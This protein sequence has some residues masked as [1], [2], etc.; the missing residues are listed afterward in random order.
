MLSVP[1]P[2]AEP[3]NGE[4]SLKRG[5]RHKR[6]FAISGDFE[7]LKKDTIKDTPFPPDTDANYATHC[8]NAPSSSSNKPELNA[9]LAFDTVDS[10]STQLFASP[11]FFISEEP[12]FTGGFK[13]VPD[14][15]INLDDALKTRPRSFKSHRRTESA[16]ADLHLSFNLERKLKI[17]EEQV[18]E[19]EEEDANAT[20]LQTNSAESS[21]TES[22]VDGNSVGIALPDS[23]ILLSPLRA[24]CPSPAAPKESPIKMSGFNTLKINKQ[25]E[26]YYNYYNKQVPSNGSGSSTIP[27]QT[28]TMSLS[29]ESSISNRQLSTPNTPVS[30]N[31]AHNR[32]VTPRNKP[33][34]YETQMYD[35]RQENEDTEVPRRSTVSTIESDDASF[36]RER[37]SSSQF[38]FNE[39]PQLPQDVLL[40][41]PGDCIDLSRSQGT[42]KVE[43]KQRPLTRKNSKRES[44]QR[45]CKHSSSRSISDPLD[46]IPVK[47]CIIPE[48]SEKKK[49]HGRFNIL[50]SLFTK[51]KR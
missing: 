2:P 35:S 17:T 46:N 47:S 39:V 6:S 10:P 20:V 13:D 37:S 15:I 22:F 25:K 26:R 24:R 3:T 27:H 28:S 38:S 41:Q 7:F 44:D 40:G 14:A 9:G 4:T 32:K 1:K 43:Q 49:K 36:S 50:S 29:S 51:P 11:R 19:E 45:S 8:S 12:K 23:T 30:A 16:P 18:A 34:K 5:H 21:S 48:S 33:F 31:H 42:S